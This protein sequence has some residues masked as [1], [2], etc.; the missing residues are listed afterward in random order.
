[1]AS[2]D[3]FQLIYRTLAPGE[4]KKRFPYMAIHSRCGWLVWFV[5]CGLL[6]SYSEFTYRIAR[7]FLRPINFT[8][9]LMN[10]HN[11]ICETKLAHCLFSVFVKF[12]FDFTPGRPFVKVLGLENF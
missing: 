8:I 11:L 12:N 1:M 10:Y 2:F 4:R 5:V 3:L 7:N 9:S 6:C